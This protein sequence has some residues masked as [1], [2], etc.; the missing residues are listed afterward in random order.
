[1]RKIILSQE[2]TDNI[3]NLYK[4]G[5]GETRV[6]NQIGVKKWIVNRILKENNISLIGTKRNK[7]DDEFFK[8]INTEEKSYWLGFLFADGYVRMRN[9]KYGEL[10]LKLQIKDKEHIHVFKDAIKSTN[11]IKDITERYTYNGEIK[12]ASS[13]TFSIYSTKI[14]N[15]LISLG[16]VPNKSK[17]IKFPDRIP[18]NLIRHFIRGYFDGDGSVF[19]K[20]NNR[21]QFYICSGS[22]E[23]LK[24]IKNEF[25][26]IGLTYQTIKEASNGVFLLRTYKINDMNKICNYFYN[27]TTVYLKRK[28][29]I[30]E[31]I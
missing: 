17:T 10:K 9:N 30:F 23:F 4:S 7:V 22:E 25:E 15:D 12:N 14:V 28:K 29:L 11:V 1:M 20:K 27:D 19:L 13:T 24:G 16:C 21:I 18:N 8:T 2:Q 31:N 5:L 6:S 26:K 3:I